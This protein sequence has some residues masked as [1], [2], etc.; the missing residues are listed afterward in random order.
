MQTLRNQI[1]ALIFYAALCACG[2]EPGSTSQEV[3]F[4]PDASETANNN[5][6][7]KDKSWTFLFYIVADDGSQS[8]DTSTARYLSTIPALPDNV[9]ALVLLDRCS[10]PYWPISTTTGQVLDSCAQL[11]QIQPDG[12]P[13]LLDTA[14][15]KLNWLQ[16]IEG[17]LNMGSANTLSQFILFGMEHSTTT[18][19]GL[20]LSGHG[21]GDQVGFDSTNDSSL[22]HAELKFAFDKALTTLARPCQ[23]KLDIV[24]MAACAMATAGMYTSLAPYAQWLIASQENIYGYNLSWMHE[25]GASSPEGYISKTEVSQALMNARIN[26]ETGTGQQVTMVLTQ[27]VAQTLDTLV[28]QVGAVLIEEGIARSTLEDASFNPRTYDFR[29]IAEKIQDEA[30][31]GK[32]DSLLDQAG[33]DQTELSEGLRDSLKACGISVTTSDLGLPGSLF[34]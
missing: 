30:L 31:L 1:I 4:N 25:L 34:F 32:V 14:P 20:I 2:S 13:H 15:Y 6:P 11:Y 18:N 17:D 12:S 23:P 9:E 28:T 27:E 16:G 26:G 8:F 33:F 24:V 3:E 29:L 7:E 19:Y 5:C 22:N 10:A 21:N